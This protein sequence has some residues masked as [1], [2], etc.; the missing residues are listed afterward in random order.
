[1][2]R[3]SKKPEDIEKILNMQK[4][5]SWAD[6]AENDT[7]VH[8][9]PAPVPAPPPASKAWKTPS[10]NQPAPSKLEFVDFEVL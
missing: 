3:Y 8:D 4:T 9:L 7:H 2:A 6:E 1:M 10:T 5:S